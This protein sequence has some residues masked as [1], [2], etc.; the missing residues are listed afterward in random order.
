MSK[1]TADSHFAGEF[2]RMAVLES[3]VG[4]NQADA[5]R[6]W[7]WLAQK[8]APPCSCKRL[9]APHALLVVQHLYDTHVV[10]RQDW[11]AERLE[12]WVR[13]KAAEMGSPL[14][15]P[16]PEVTAFDRKFCSEMRI[17]L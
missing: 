13:A 17:A 9:M 14:P 15:M 12:T 1:Q 4:F 6:Q 5:K 16:A 11:K 7:P 2:Y 3:N 8:V 10:D